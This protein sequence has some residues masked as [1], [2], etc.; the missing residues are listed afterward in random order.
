MINKFLILIILFPTL[1]YAQINFSELYEKSVAS[2]Q[3]YDSLIA[4]KL[5]Q[6]NIFQVHKLDD[7]ISFLTSVYP[8]DSLPITPTYLQIYND[9]FNFMQLFAE[10]S[11][12][13]FG[14][15]LV[16]GY[17]FIHDNSEFVL[18][19]FLNA[20]ANCHFCQPLTLIFNISPSRNV[21][22]S[23]NG[24][25]MGSEIGIIGILNNELVLFPVEYFKTS[26]QPLWY[27][28]VKKEFVTRNDSYIWVDINPTTHQMTVNKNKSKWSHFF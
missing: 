16:N 3:L 1:G 11:N 18:L 26:F 4:S 5:I 24:T 14:V 23:Y 12:Y 2:E 13:S 8:Q 20:N 9:T 15:D 22:L 21:S 7:S 10:D 27:D 28:K 25:Q 19:F 6:N 17:R